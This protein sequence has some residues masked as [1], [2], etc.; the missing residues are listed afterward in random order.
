[1]F[2]H[3]YITK[4]YTDYFRTKSASYRGGLALSGAGRPG[5]GSSTYVLCSYGRGTW[6]TVGNAITRFRTWDA[7]SSA[8]K[9]AAGWTG[10]SKGY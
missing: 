4:A 1:M 2:R 7:C 8:T 10:T 9:G 5:T 6:R 3:P